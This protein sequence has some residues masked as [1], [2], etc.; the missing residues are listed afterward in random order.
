MYSIPVSLIE[1]AFT[2]KLRKGYLVRPCFVKKEKMFRQN[3]QHLQY[4]LLFR[5]NSLFDRL[6]D[7]EIENK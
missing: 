6:P 3:S 5:Q 2:Y 4:F 7:E 1:K